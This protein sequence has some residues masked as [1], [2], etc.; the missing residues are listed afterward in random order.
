MK[1]A[2]IVL[3]VPESDDDGGGL[4]TGSDERD[5]EKEDEE[6]DERVAGAVALP[7]HGET[8]LVQVGLHDDQLELTALATSGRCD[9]LPA[10]HTRTVRVISDLERERE[11]EVVNKYKKQKKRYKKK[12]YKKYK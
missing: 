11:R 1:G 8:V 4:G 12:K 2:G 10:L 9:D 6:G 3:N 5:D 7:G